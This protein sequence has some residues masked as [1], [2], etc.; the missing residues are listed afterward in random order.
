MSD[1]MFNRPRRQTEP[2]APDERGRDL[3][4]SQS[5][6]PDAGATE[7]R[8]QGADALLELARLIGQSDPFAPVP[9]RADNSHKA[10]GL[11]ADN[12]RGSPSPALGA[13]DAFIRPSMREPVQSQDRSHEIRP[14][15]DRFR[16]DRFRAQRQFEDR[17]FGDRSSL[18]GAIS[19]R[20]DSEFGLPRAPIQPIHPDVDHPNAAP[21]NFD[22]RL[23]GRDEYSVAPR[24]SGA[25]EANYDE[26][27]DNEDPLE[28][29]RHSAYGRE[30][31]EYS[32]KYH[33]DE[34]H[35]DEYEQDD[36]EYEHDHED[37]EDGESHHKRR[38]TAKM[39]IA[40][41][42]LAVFGSA[43][44]FGYRTVF[45]VAPSGP[46]PI[47][48]ADN[49]PTKITPVVADA[50]A[51][52]INERLGDRS[53]EQLVRRDEDPLDVGSSYRAAGTSAPG[54]LPDG[55]G[56]SPPDTIPATVGPSDPRRVRTVTIRPDQS[57]ASPDRPTPDR[58]AP[59]DRAASDRMTPDRAA[60]RAPAPQLQSQAQPQSAPP[61]PQRQAAISP[62]PAAI[63]APTAIAPDAAPTR[64][65]DTGGFVVQ[66][67]AQR[68]EAD[69]QAAFRNLQ[70]KY[71]ALGGREPLIRRKDLGERGVFYAA[72][73]GP[74]SVK[75]EADQ[76]CETLKAAGGACFV[77]RN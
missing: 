30:D 23:P 54:P 12:S 35:E 13:K 15:E 59:S 60:S 70:A 26:H 5:R 18:D 4:G 31:D 33:E 2:R 19:G 51:K 57:G 66:L 34:Y 56:A 25:D 72:Q 7:R 69:A 47:I 20:R 24:H 73:V 68:S 50:N 53:G 52:P 75:T 14:N 21:E 38:S 67:S 63:A 43:A 65:V 17:P 28:A 41:L 22:L 74:F 3:A 32:D 64:A 76:F 36:Y 29:Q 9:A 39:A 27:D 16:D 48:R 45:K 11:S 58:P 46:T 61:P 55:A 40:V 77:Q 62:P 42:G 10:E 71:S 49:S 44:A 8:D 37:P 1:S 6:T